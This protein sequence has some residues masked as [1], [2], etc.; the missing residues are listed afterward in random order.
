MMYYFFYL[1]PKQINVYDVDFL[2]T[3]L[4]NF[5]NTI[6]RFE[7]IFSIK[8][9]GSIQNNN[10]VCCRYNL[11]NWLK[12][13]WKISFFHN[14]NHNDARISM[15]VCVV[16]VISCSGSISFFHRWKWN[17]GQSCTLFYF[18]HINANTTLKSLT[19]SFKWE[20]GEEVTF[21]NFTFDIKV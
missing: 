15:K 2:S 3:D 19:L 20:I 14:L 16:H 13:D 6:C 10:S 18:H 21:I 11:C 8:K 1:S 9:P 5:L 12:H 4:R 17:Y 7:Q